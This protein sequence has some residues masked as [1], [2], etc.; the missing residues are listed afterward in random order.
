[1]IKSNIFFPYEKS[2]CV[3]L[4]Y[5]LVTNYSIKAKSIVELSLNKFF[6]RQYS[7]IT[8]AINGYYCPRKQKEKNE[9]ARKNSR[10]KINNFLFESATERARDIYPF[11]IDITGN[12]KKHSN[13]SPDRSHI[14]SGSIAGM[15]VGHYYSFICLKDTDSW[16]PPVAIDRIP[17]GENKMEFSVSQITPILKKLPKDS[18]GLCIGDSAYSCNKFV[19]PLY[20]LEHV[21][22]ITRARS[23][24]A[25]YKKYNDKKEGVGRK[26]QYGDKSSLNKPDSLPTPDSTEEFEE[27]LKKGGA[28]TVRLA[29][30]EGYIC[31]GSKDYK[32][33]DVEINFVKVEILKENGERKYDRDLWIE[34]I[35]KK[36]ADISPINVYL[37]YKGRFDVEHLFKF[38]KSKLLMDKFE[39]SDPKR[40]EDFMMFGAIA[41]HVLCKCSEI[42]KE[43]QIRPWE[44]KEKVDL[45]S[46]STIYRA[47]SFSGIF[48]NIYQDDLKKRG[49]PDERNIR[50]IFAKKENKPIM[51]KAKDPSK[52][53]I[54]IKSTFENNTTF[55]KTSLNVN[56]SLKENF[57]A[58]CA[59]KI[60]E[61]YAKFQT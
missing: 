47:A 22:T 21:V 36:K 14:Y 11:V 31:R 12:I 13:K 9:E 61:I 1:L 6:N 43:C 15:S 8:R 52:L 3:D 59:K 46:P 25:I 42:L 4:I 16:M 57:Q 50:K 10:N 20:K 19:Q 28:Q 26:R 49:I 27:V 37:Y 41:Y 51:R 48:D 44:N 30:Y 53:S 32:M 39:S 5:A 55:S 18:I 54:E 33:S 34:V 38:G 24:K 23:N 7:S 40:D 60:A 58:I 17:F 56:E 45:K 35:G 2:A 29:V